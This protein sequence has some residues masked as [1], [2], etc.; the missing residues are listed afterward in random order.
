MKIFYFRV[1]DRTTS[2]NLSPEEIV[3]RF[4]RRTPH[5][6]KGKV[7]FKR[8]EGIYWQ[9]TSKKLNTIYQDCKGYEINRDMVVLRTKTSSIYNESF[10]TLAINYVQSVSS[11]ET[12]Q[13]LQDCLDA[14]IIQEFTIDK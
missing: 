2:R 11:E 14:L 8:D 13:I 12:I 10:P 6:T 7:K 3:D 9:V 1:Q 5:K 4:S